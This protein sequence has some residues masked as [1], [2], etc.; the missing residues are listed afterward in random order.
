[1]PVI[2]ALSEAK[3]G[4]SPEVGSSRPAWHGETLSLWKIQN[5]ARCGG[6]V[7][8]IPATQEAET[9]ESLEPRRQRLQWAEI[10]PLHSSLGNRARL[11][12]KKKKEETREDSG[13]KGKRREGEKCW[14]RRKMTACE[15]SVDYC[16]LVR[17]IVFE[18]LV[19]S[20]HWTKWFTWVLLVNLHKNSLSAFYKWGNWGIEELN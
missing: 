3:V 7:S 20:R 10:A 15:L 14:V 1:M 19:S 12:L 17:T 13:R 8:V 6:K 9:G 11:C 4:R 16:G 5:L 2:P 18:D